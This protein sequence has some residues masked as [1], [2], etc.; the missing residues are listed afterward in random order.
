MPEFQKLPTKIRFMTRVLLFSLVLSSSAI[1]QELCMPRNVKAAYKFNLRSKDGKPGPRYFQNKSVH[2]IDI[3]LNPPNRRVTGSQKIVYTNNS[4]LALNAV[5]LR[6]EMN[7][8]S[9]EAMR[10]RVVE[11]EVLAPDVVIDEFSEDGTVRPYKPL[12]P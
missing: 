12:I 11:S 10:E 8:R 2:D 5:Y 7:V 1:A 6:F 4:P 9:P 3:T